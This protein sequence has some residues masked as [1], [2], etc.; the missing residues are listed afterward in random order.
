MTRRK[1]Q[2]R[3]TPSSSPTRGEDGLRL[4]DHDAGA[5][6]A[7]SGD[8]DQEQEINPYG[9]RALRSP[10]ADTG[11]AHVVSGDV[12]QENNSFGQ[13]APRSPAADA[14]AALEGGDADR[15]NPA[16]TAEPVPFSDEQRKAAEEA[17][18]LTDLLSELRKLT[19]ERDSRERELLERIR[20]F[21]AGNPAP[22]SAETRNPNLFQ[23]E[24]GRDAPASTEFPKK[25]PTPLKDQ[26]VEGT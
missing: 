10:A 14:E 9:Q 1:G 13:S 26:P 3:K 7:E 20:R 6:H 16:G 11:A 23:L 22:S 12:D 18:M 19:E 24:Y 21:E 25:F 2:A 5:A 8:A 15:L 17:T 4:L